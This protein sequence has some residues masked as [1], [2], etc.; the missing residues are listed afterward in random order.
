MRS[1]FF[2]GGTSVCMQFVRATV[3][4]ESATVITTF[5]I[6][7]PGVSVRSGCDVRQSLFVSIGPKKIPGEAIGQERDYALKAE[8]KSATRPPSRV[9]I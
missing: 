1:D 7:C 6:L 4:Y 9:F 5:P 8:P 3:F 2:T